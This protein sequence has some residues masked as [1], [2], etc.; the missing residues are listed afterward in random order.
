MNLRHLKE[1]NE[2]RKMDDRPLIVIEKKRILDYAA[3]SFDALHWNGRQIRNAFQTALALAEF[4]AQSS[5]TKQ[6]I[7]GKDQFKSIA[8]ASEQFDL[9]LKKTHGMDEGRVAERDRVRADHFTDLKGVLE[10]LSDS[11][12]EASESDSS[13]DSDNEAAKSDGD[14]SDSVAGSSN[15]S[16]DDDAKRKKKRKDKKGK[17]KADL[18]KEKEKRD[19]KEKKEKK[20]KKVKFKNKK[21]KVESEDSD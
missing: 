15:D 12:S 11:E 21:E 14:D 10:D 4:K 8:I 18:K 1:K 13:D 6:P 16:S 9:Y 2:S 17:S 3:S 20:D 19:K 7:I 5:K